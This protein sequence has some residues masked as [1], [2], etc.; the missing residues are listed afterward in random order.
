MFDLGADEMDA[1]WAGVDESGNGWISRPMAAVLL[2]RA[3]VLQHG[4][5]QAMV[6]EKLAK[7]ED[8]EAGVI[9]GIPKFMQWCAMRP[10]AARL[11]HCRCN[12]TSSL[13]WVARPCHLYSCA[14]SGACYSCSAT[15]AALRW[16]FS[17][18]NLMRMA[19]HP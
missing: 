16:C 8:I 1:L 6:E 19:A 18:D 2:K 11:V 9:R 3:V 13:A 14:A 12:T 5:M 15:G 4:K 17:V 7:E 10:K